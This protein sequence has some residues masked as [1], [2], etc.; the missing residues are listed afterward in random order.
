MAL[1]KKSEQNWLNMVPVVKK[2]IGT[3]IHDEGLVSITIPRFNKKWMAKL[4]FPKN[5]KNEILVDFD[6]N[7][8]AVWLQIDGKKSIKEIIAALNEIAKSEKD[9]NN[10][11]VLFLQNIYRSGFI[12][13]N[14]Q[15]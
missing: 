8:T 3:I 6:A 7:G 12:E 13:V 4:F 5:K 11:V 10:R 9:Y 1:G 15:S 14:Y 2:T